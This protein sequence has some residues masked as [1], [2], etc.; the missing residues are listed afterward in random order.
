MDGNEDGDDFLI[1]DMG[2]KMNGNMNDTWNENTMNW[3][4]EWKNDGEKW[5]MMYGKMVVYY[6]EIW[7]DENEAT[8]LASCLPHYSSYI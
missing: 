8:N 6:D 7:M 4:D 2:M 1:D 5:W 3:V